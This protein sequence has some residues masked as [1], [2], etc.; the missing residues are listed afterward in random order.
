MVVVAVRPLVPA[1]A[2]F[3]GLMLLLYQAV[4]LRKISAGVIE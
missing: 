3:G 1:A 2:G 4:E